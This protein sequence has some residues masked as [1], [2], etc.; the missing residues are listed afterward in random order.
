MEEWQV[1]LKPNRFNPLYPLK[2]CYDI[3]MVF[4]FFVKSATLEILAAQFY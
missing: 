2:G 1:V 4:F 3:I